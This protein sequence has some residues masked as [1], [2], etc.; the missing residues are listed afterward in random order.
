MGTS[1]KWKITGLALGVLLLCSLGVLGY[2]LYSNYCYRRALGIVSEDAGRA[3]AMVRFYQG[4]LRIYE[5]DKSNREGG[6]S[7]RR[8]GPFE[9]WFD[10]YR[11]EDPEAWR[12]S[13]R[14]FWEEHNKMM[15][16]MQEHPGRFRA[17]SSAVTNNVSNGTK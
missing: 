12:Y 5:I 10:P 7:G 3:D 13:R 14:V 2:A 9:L 15:H 16:Y 17:G 6:F 8:E 1:K 4:H 11:A